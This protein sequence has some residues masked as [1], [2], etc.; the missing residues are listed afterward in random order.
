MK[1]N[2]LGYRT[3]TPFELL[4][5]FTNEELND[6]EKLINS[7]YLSTKQD[8]DVLLKNLRKHA[9]FHTAF[10]P[11][12]Q[13]IIYYSLF[14]EEPQAEDFLNN[15]QKKKLSKAMNELLNTAKNFI[16]FEKV[17][18]SDEHEAT[19]LYPTL[20]NR[21]QLLLYNKCLKATEKKLLNTKKQGEAYYNQCYNIQR[22]KARLSF[23]NN[24][25]SKADN[26][27]ELQYHGDVKYLL[28]KLQYHLAKIT[29]RRRYAHKTFNLKPF[30][31][32]QNLLELSEYQSNPLIQLYLL[33][34][35]LVESEEEATFIALSKL[36]KEKQTVIPADFLNI[37][38]VNLTNYCAYQLSKG[39]SNYYKY[40]FKIYSDM[41]EGKLL[42]SDKF[43][44]LALL[45]NMV[46]A[47]C[48]VDA[49]GWAVEKLN[50]YIKYVPKNIRK[51]VFEYNSG[52][53]AFHQRKYEVALTHFAKVRKI[54]NTHE[55]GFR[56]VQLMCFYETDTTYETYTQQIIKTLKT[57][58][59]DNKKL[60]KR[61]KT[62]H[63]N[64]I[65][66]LN[67]LYK[68]KDVP[69]RRSQRVEINKTL[70]KL[71]AQIM[72]FNLISNKQWLFNKIE[73]LENI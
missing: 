66:I 63:Y 33:N 13:R 3:S 41:D 21:K 45:K 20:I 70:P 8:L 7:G 48:Q 46:T 60:T 18:E 19:L 58:I 26:Y 29:L 67:K 14:P 61:Q 59:H 27:D 22:E 2:S 53:I 49:F 31:L 69:D 39:D 23:I 42:I 52:I 71:K 1:N 44:E 55:L 54:D 35:K 32:L 15:S 30:D 24:T 11:N 10:T 36:L 43:I 38:Y 16:M 62:S 68:L 9:L 56:M 65:R 73:I 57:Y 6:F 50:S 34:I 51:S 5:T 40:I 4:K 17:K 64:F 25:L 12:I 72:K 28:Q 47:S 37:F